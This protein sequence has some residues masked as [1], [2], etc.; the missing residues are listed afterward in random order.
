MNAQPRTGSALPRPNA[1]RHTSRPRDIRRLPIFL[2]NFIRRAARYAIFKATN[3]LN[4][5]KRIAIK[6]TIFF[7]L[8]SW[9]LRN[10]PLTVILAGQPCLLLPRGN[11]AAEVWAGRDL[12]RSEIDFAVACLQPGMTFF[13]VGA[14]VGL[15]S[16][17]AARKLQHGR[18]YAF[19]PTAQTFQ[20]LLSHATLN[21]LTNLHGVHSAVGDHTGE[22]VLQINAP[23][24]DGLN[25][26]GKPAH[27]DSHIVATETVPITTLD[28]FIH[29]NSIQHVD[30]LKVDVE[31][32][33]LLV[34][35]G[36]QNLLARPDAPII[37]YESGCLTAGFG[38]HPVESMWLLQSHGYHFFMISANGRITPLPGSPPHDAMLIA[39]KA[40]HPS[41]TSLQDRSR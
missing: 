7:P 14:N 29:L 18:V 17:P 38:Y 31:G 26:I 13:D 28:Q 8:R 32:A 10:K 34:F 21:R 39:A 20:Q 1:A 36:A 15:F 22:V 40:A 4:R 24:K 37:L 23:G 9:L 3:V 12:E 30:M 27:Q 11:V 5:Q 25:T 41:Y 16:I 19:E 35:R 6:R 33:D 2:A